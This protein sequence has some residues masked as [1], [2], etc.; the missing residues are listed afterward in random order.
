MLPGILI[1]AGVLAATAVTVVLVGRRLPVQHTAA[2]RISLRRT[3]EEVWDILAAVDGY[4]A[5]R[6]G[7]RRVEILPDVAGL[8]R[9]AEHER[10][11]KVTFEAAEAVRP[12]RF[13]SRIAEPGLPFAGTWTYEITPAAHGCV[14]TVTEDGEVHNP[15]FRFISRYVIGHTATLDRN[16]KA[17]A[18]HVEQ[19]DQHAQ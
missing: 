6:P 15:V 4:A 8:M 19:G 17:L 7:V 14:L 1:A 9:W 12:S 18:A 10:H 11:G 5:W 16:L 13:T 2:R 3:P